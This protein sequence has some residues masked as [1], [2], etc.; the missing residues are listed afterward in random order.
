MDAR[1]L[2]HF[3]EAGCGGAWSPRLFEPR[4]WWCTGGAAGGNSCPLSATA[5]N[6]TGP[7]NHLRWLWL[8]AADCCRQLDRANLQDRSPA[9]DATS[10]VGSIPMRFRHLLR[11]HRTRMLIGR[12]VLA[13][14]SGALERPM[15]FR[16]LLRRHRMRMLIGRRVLVCGSGALEWPSA[17]PPDPAAIDS[18]QTSIRLES[19][20]ETCAAPSPL[21]R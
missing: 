19:I 14:G 11:R 2:A 17:L 3:A 4:V 20:T 1:T 12:R 5:L 8:P 15:R 10:G 16:H 6:K 13:C 21:L 18:V 9:W 7:R